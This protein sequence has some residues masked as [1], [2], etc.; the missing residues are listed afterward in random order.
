MTTLLHE[1]RITQSVEGGPRKADNVPKPI[2]KTGRSAPKDSSGVGGGPNDPKR[3]GT[4]LH[5]SDSRPDSEWPVIRVPARIHAALTKPGESVGAST[6]WQAYILLDYALTA[7][8]E[9][10]I[11]LIDPAEEW[12]RTQKMGGDES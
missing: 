2:C 4:N 9:G 11:V 1:H 8:E 10:K 7:L 6:N 12:A 5:K 3:P